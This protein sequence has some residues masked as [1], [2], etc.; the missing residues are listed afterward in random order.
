MFFVILLVATLVAAGANQPASPSIDIDYGQ[1]KLTNTGKCTI[2]NDDLSYNTSVNGIVP[3]L[4]FG[5]IDINCDNIA[6]TYA[7]VPKC[8]PCGLFCVQNEHIVNCQQTIVPFLS[9][10]VMTS[11]VL[12]IVHIIC[13]KRYTML[14]N[15]FVSYLA[16]RMHYYNDKRKLKYALKMKEHGHEKAHGNLTEPKFMSIKHSERLQQKR[17][18]KAMKYGL[19]NINGT[20]IDEQEPTAPSLE[21]ME[22]HAIP[23]IA[24]IY[25][26]VEKEVVLVNEIKVK[27]DNES[28]QQKAKKGNENKDEEASSTSGT[29]TN[30]VETVA[31][32]HGLPASV[33]ARPLIDCF[34]TAC[35]AMLH[36]STIE[37]QQNGLRLFETMM[38]RLRIGQENENQRE[39]ERV[40]KE[41]EKKIA[42]YGKM[43]EV[44]KDV[45]KLNKEHDDYVHKIQM[46][47]EQHKL[48]KMKELRDALEDLKSILNEEPCKPFKEKKNKKHDDDDDKNGSNKSSLPKTPKLSNVAFIVMMVLFGLISAVIGCDSTLFIHANGK[49]CDSTKC[50]DITTFSFPIQTGSTICFD[51]M[52]DNVFKISITKTNINTHYQLVYRTSGYDLNVKH[53]SVCAGK[54]ECWRDACTMGYKHSVYEN[55]TNIPYGND[56]IWSQ[57][58]C[59]DNCWHGERCNYLQWSIEKKDKISNVYKATHQIWEVEIKTNYKKLASTFK[60][61]VNN[62]SID[63]VDFGFEGFEKMPV[64]INSFISESVIINNHLLIDHENNVYNVRASEENMPESDIIG[65][66]QIELFGNKTIFNKDLVSCRVEECGLK[67]SAPQSKLERFLSSKTKKQYDVT[68]GFKYIDNLNSIVSSEVKSTMNLIIGNAEFNNLRLEKASCLFEPVMSYSCKGCSKRQYVILQA[69]KIKVMGIMTFTSNCNYNVDYLSCSEQPFK[70]INKNQVENCWIYIKR[71]N[72]TIK[73][74]SKIE[75]LS[76]LDPTLMIINENDYRQVVSE[77]VSSP[78]FLNGIIST[79]GMYGAVTIIIGFLSRLLRLYLNERMINKINESKV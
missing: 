29:S 73:I 60:L 26:N 2:T 54:G 78:S 24:C 1:V 31:T 57:S 35:D 13:T 59:S 16:M 63:L 77:M 43:A 48:D 55:L 5:L 64:I 19:V 4:W 46:K 30:V 28:K 23:K 6:G 61:N 8:K 32:I 67:C 50:M 69:Y 70:L 44:F 47:E 71:T 74:K 49:M 75:D 7:S 17:L 76:Q 42:A 52:T 27:S 41:S 15:N 33:L 38:T 10:A 21:D 22:C 12:L 25:P 51:D 11:L 34:D 20:E 56:C 72:Q 68:D 14:M 62:P 37:E 65:D 53:H 18:N 66:L 40:K 36:G 58:G 45:S 9:G 79:I 39:S 3:G